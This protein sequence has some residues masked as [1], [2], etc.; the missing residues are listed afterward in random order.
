MGLA[1]VSD[2]GASFLI[3]HW[4]NGPSLPSSKMLRVKVPG[5]GSRDG[6]FSVKLC[7]E[8]AWKSDTPPVS[9]RCTLLPFLIAWSRALYLINLAS[10]SAE[11]LILWGFVVESQDIQKDAQ[12]LNA[13]LC[14]T[15]LKVLWFLRISGLMERIYHVLVMIEHSIITEQGFHEFH[16]LQEFVFW[17][18]VGSWGIGIVSVHMLS[19]WITE[20]W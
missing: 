14:F 15:H 12:F 20:S 5:S 6:N 16:I 3:S 11:V 17:K 4:Q 13:P 19:L 10:L 2:C 7:S 18:N 1:P 9:W 8:I